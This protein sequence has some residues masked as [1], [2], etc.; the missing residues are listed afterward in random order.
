M[1]NERIQKGSY[2]SCVFLKI[3]IKNRKLFTP[4]KKRE[5]RFYRNSLII[6]GRDDRI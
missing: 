3:G 4:D 6:N 2:L 1:A 5:L